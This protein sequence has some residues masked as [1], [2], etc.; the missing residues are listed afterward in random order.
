MLNVIF[1][2]ALAIMAER[3]NS[4]AVYCGWGTT[5]DTMVEDYLCQGGKWSLVSKVLNLA[6]YR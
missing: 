4:T 3:Q 1:N 2:E 6:Y 5:M